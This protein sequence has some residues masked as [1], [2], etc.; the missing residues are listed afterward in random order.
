MSFQ[1]T[2]YSDREKAEF[3]R[4]HFAPLD[5]AVTF[6]EADQKVGPFGGEYVKDAE[7]CG[8]RKSPSN[9]QSTKEWFECCLWVVQNVRRLKGNRDTGKRGLSEEE[10]Q[11]YFGYLSPKGYTWPRLNSSAAAYIAHYN[12]KKKICEA[13]G[14]TKSARHWTQLRDEMKDI[15]D[16]I[17]AKNLAK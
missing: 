2:I 10:F 5:T 1:V 6:H 3:R 14:W 11:R 12:L 17:R 15:K 4:K 16:R 8:L 7:L 9:I 13:M